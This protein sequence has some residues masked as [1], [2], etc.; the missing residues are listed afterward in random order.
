MLNDTVDR[1]RQRRRRIHARR[2]QR[3]R[4]QLML[5]GAVLL[6]VIMSI[7]S[8]TANHIHKKK[9]Q[10]TAGIEKEAEKEQKKEKAK[11]SKETPGDRLMRVKQEAEAAGCPEEIVELLTKNEETIEFVEH[12]SEKKDLPSADTVG[13]VTKGVIPHLLQWDERWGYAAYGT[14]TV[15]VSGCGPTCMSMVL[16]GLTGD[17]SITPAK[18]AAYGMENGYID[19]TNDTV[20]LF[21]EQASLNW[22]VSCFEINNSENVVAAELASGHP[23]I[24]SM[25]PGDFTSNGHF[26]VLTDYDDGNVRVLDPFSRENS[27]K[28]WS[29]EEIVD[30]FQAMWAYYYE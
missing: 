25:G 11:E 19:D 4:R 15:A 12:Y 29:Y 6:L 13:E 9:A 5:I 20:W 2:R 7:I 14:S 27:E 16:T 10:E 1:N 30:Q 18:V 26:I 21:M 24:C 22:G 17:A 28:M 3:V 8:C 23:V